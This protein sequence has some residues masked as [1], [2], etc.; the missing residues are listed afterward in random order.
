VTFDGKRLSST[1]RKSVVTTI[2]YHRPLTERQVVIII[3]A[4][5]ALFTL[6]GVLTQLFS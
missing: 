4:I 3:S 6:L 5:V 1:S 2:T